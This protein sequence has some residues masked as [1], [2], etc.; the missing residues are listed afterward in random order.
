MS[1]QSV[2][3]NYLTYKLDK[4]FHLLDQ[5]IATHGN[6]LPKES[7]AALVRAYKPDA[8]TYDEWKQ[9]LHAHGPN[10]EGPDEDPE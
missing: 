10:P 9:R 3:I 2:D 6:N 7:L 1:R 8:I 4:V 5:F